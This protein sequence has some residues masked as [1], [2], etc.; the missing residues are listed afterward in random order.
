M[1]CKLLMPIGCV[2]VAVIVQLLDREGG[3]DD[4]TVPPEMARLYPVVWNHY[5][6]YPHFAVVYDAPKVTVVV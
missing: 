5:S 6:V 1:Y 2:K 4:K 3:V